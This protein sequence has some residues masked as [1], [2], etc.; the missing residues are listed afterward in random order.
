MESKF[1]AA[2]IVGVIHT[3]MCKFIV[4]H[5]ITTSPKKNTTDSATYEG[6]DLHQID[7]KGRCSWQ[8]GKS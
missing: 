5:E 2:K 3:A 7:Q 6:N 8:R 1:S 4:L